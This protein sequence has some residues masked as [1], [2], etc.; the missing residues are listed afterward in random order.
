MKYLL[1]ILLLLLAPC[2]GESFGSTSAEATVQNTNDNDT[3]IARFQMGA[4]GGTTDSVRVKAAHGGETGDKLVVVIYEDDS[5]DPTTLLKQFTSDTITVVDAG[6]TNYV[7][8]VSGDAYTLVADTWYWIGVHCAVIDTDVQLLESSSQDPHRAAY[9]TGNENAPNPFDGT[10]Y[11]SGG[12]VEGIDI[13]IF[14]TTGGGSGGTIGGETFGGV[15]L[16]GQ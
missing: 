3:R 15:T 13:Q 4:T 11:A 12:S 6:L 10:I 7:V 9:D 1:A 8:D 2:L 16:G 14:Y 5:D